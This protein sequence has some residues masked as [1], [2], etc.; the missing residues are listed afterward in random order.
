[1]IQRKPSLEA[2]LRRASRITERQFDKM[3]AVEMCQLAEL[4]RAVA[5]YVVGGKVALEK[6]KDAGAV[7]LLGQ[8]K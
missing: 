1:M 8:L 2:L 7:K 5:L 4:L 6:R 3:G